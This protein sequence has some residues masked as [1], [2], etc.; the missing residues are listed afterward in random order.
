M[1]SVPSVRQLKTRTQS[2]DSPVHA[3]RSGDAAL[4]VRG[5]H[6]EVQPMDVHI[7]ARL[8]IV[9]DSV[10]MIPVRLLVLCAVNAPIVAS[11]RASLLSDLGSMLRGFAR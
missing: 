9:E 8:E 1:M 3:E 7:K 5:L 11:P 2:R 4:F 10:K 6:P